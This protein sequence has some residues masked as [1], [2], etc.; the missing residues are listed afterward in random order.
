MSAPTK[1]RDLAVVAAAYLATLGAVV[2]LAHLDAFTAPV[3]ALAGSWGLDPALALGFA[4]DLA[5][6]VIVF[7]FS[8]V[9]K[10]AST[11]DAYWSVAPI[12]LVFYWFVPQLSVANP[13]R[14]AVVAALVGWWGWRLTYSWARGWPGLHH[15]DFRYRD[16]RAKTGVFYPAVN[17][18]GI[19]LFPT[20]QVFLGMLPVHAVA[21][22]TAPFGVVDVVAALVAAAAIL[23]EQVADRQ[24]HE[25]RL[26][27]AR[28]EASPVLNTGLWAWSRH[29][30]YLGEMG[31]WWGLALF[32]VAVGAEW[33]RA[34][35]ALAITV[36]FVFVSLPMIEGR[37]R[38]RR[39]EYEELAA[40][41]V[42]LPRPPR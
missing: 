41:G 12:A 19:H 40:R 15:E 7:G 21:S 28:G 23:T 39:P 38:A 30:N 32:A 10:N 6:T 29:P 17:L 25:Y 42:L 1:G 20:V 13:A 27:K 22:S 37:H 26:R 4:L 16:L 18:L 36:M 24:L 2:G 11:Y 8:L 34:S 31:F 9:L 5:A 3:A 14:L 33:W 35:G